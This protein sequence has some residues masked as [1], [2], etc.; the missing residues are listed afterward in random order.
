MYV[1]MFDWFVPFGSRQNTIGPHLDKL[2]E[3]H[4]RYKRFTSNVRDV[5]T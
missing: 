2:A 3:D 1:C 5:I 4:S